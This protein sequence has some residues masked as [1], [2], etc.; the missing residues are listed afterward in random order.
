VHAKDFDSTIKPTFLATGDGYVL[1]AYDGDYIPTMTKTGVVKLVGTM[2]H[3][4]VNGLR[5]PKKL[6]FDSTVDGVPNATELAFT[7]YTIKKK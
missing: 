5:L 2:E 4:F 6:A 7:D 3:S 1:A